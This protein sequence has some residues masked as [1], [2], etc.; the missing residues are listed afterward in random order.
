MRGLL[1]SPTTTC[2]HPHSWA[3]ACPVLPCLQCDI[4]YGCVGCAVSPTNCTECYSSYSDSYTLVGGKCVPNY[5]QN[6][7]GVDSCGSCT[8]KRC[9]ACET[10]YAL[11][12]GE[13][14]KCDSGYK[15]EFTDCLSCR[16]NNPRFC[17]EW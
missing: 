10:G 17:L 3:H 12:K 7:T 11:V 6:V 8:G 14:R 15:P 4:P 13:C 9:T 2:T 5:C 16:P 1:L